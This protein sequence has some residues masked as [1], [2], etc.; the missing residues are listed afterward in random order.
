MGPRT[1]RI[2][3]HGARVL[4]AGGATARVPG[5][6]PGIGRRSEGRDVRTLLS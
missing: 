6:P 2:Q 4:I 1:R 3:V 5:A